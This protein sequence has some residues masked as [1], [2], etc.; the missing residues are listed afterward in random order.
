MGSWHQIANATTTIAFSL[1]L[2]FASQ[3]YVASRS[4]AA[5]VKASSVAALRH[6]GYRAANGR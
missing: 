2:L 3:M 4:A 5:G 6:A 1:A